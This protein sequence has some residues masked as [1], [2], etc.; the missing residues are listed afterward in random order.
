MTRIA[1]PLALT[2][3]LACAGAPPRR[4]R[5]PSASPIESASSTKRYGPCDALPNTN[6]I[7]ART[8][9]PPAIAAI[10]SATADHCLH[11]AQAANAE[12]ASPVH[13]IVPGGNSCQIS[14][15]RAPPPDVAKSAPRRSAERSSAP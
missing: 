13:S 15:R 8:A 10:S 12:S 2:S 9:I 11:A 6:A 4:T 1:S 3:C 14:T 5:E 7:A